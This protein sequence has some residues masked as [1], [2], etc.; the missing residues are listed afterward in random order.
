MGFTEWTKD[1]K[2]LLSPSIDDAGSLCFLSGQESRLLQLQPEGLLNKLKWMFGCFS[3]FM[4]CGSVTFLLHVAGSLWIFYSQDGGSV[5]R[6]VQQDGRLRRLGGVDRSVCMGNRVPDTWEEKH[7]QNTLYTHCIC[8][9][10]CLL[11]YCAVT[12]PFC[13]I[14]FRIFSP[15]FSFVS[16]FT[17][18]HFTPL[19]F[20]IIFMPSPFIPA[21]HSPL[22]VYNS[23]LSHCYFLHRGMVW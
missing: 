10:G 15:F 7:F 23:P 12:F 3:Y 14:C 17:S 13:P 22:H 8:L 18:L 4:K 5:F 21:L 11:K 19:Q 16:F 9:F 1:G 20:D 2:H 6:K